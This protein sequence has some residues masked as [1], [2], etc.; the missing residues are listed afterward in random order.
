MKSQLSCDNS[1]LNMRTAS[2]IRQALRA[3]V[4]LLALFTAT[5]VAAGE[6]ASRDWIVRM[7]AALQSRNYLG[8]LV[9]QVGPYKEV[10]RIIHRSQPGQMKER[11][12]M[13]SPFPG[14][15]YLR[16]GSDWMVYSPEQRTVRLEK[17]YRNYGYLTALNGFSNETG[18]Y[19]AL[20][21]GGSVA[22]DG[23]MARVISLEPRDALRYGY[24][25][26]LEE[27]TALPLKTQLVTSSGKVIEETY[28]ISLSLPRSISDEQLKPKI[29]SAIR[30]MKQR[31]LV[32]VAGDPA[33]FR[34]RSDLL[35]A[36]FRVAP[37][38]SAGRDANT[39]GQGTR[40]IV[41]D[42]ISWVSVVV[43]QAGRNPSLSDVEGPKD[44]MRAA[45]GN[46]RTDGVAVMG[47]TAAYEA[48]VNGFTITVVGEV[49]P[50]TVK[51]I[52]E[53]IRPE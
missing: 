53:A 18:R 44:K 9:H 33:R 15:E 10:L 27:K 6:D 28:F 2:S 31:E 45:A 41:T 25:F 52:A 3:A 40:F 42:S 12:I 7:N 32:E 47:S 43:E 51:A 20:S 17:R 1:R 46:A 37:F 21:D 50:S 29:D 5:A 35:P 4:A 48:K 19:Y 13:V 38:F 49:P 22:L 34:P 8:V 14:L 26:W 24:R 11:V 30:G 36:G 39:A 23:W 16:D